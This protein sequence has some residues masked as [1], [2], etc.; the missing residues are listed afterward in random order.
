MYLWRNLNRLDIEVLRLVCLCILFNWTE[1]HAAKCWMFHAFAVRLVKGLKLNLESPGS[2][3]EQEA[4]RRLVWFVFV[5]EI[6]AALSCPV[7]SGSL[8]IDASRLSGSIPLGNHP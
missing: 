6:L 2:F 3:T 4:T 5:S 7:E 8:V 1:A